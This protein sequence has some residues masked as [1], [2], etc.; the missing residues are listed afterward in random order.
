MYSKLVK[1]SADE[2]RWFC[3]EPSNSTCNMSNHPNCCN[4][5]HQIIEKVKRIVKEVYIPEVF[6]EFKNIFVQT[7]LTTVG[8]PVLSQH[9]IDWLM[10]TS[11]IY[12]IDNIAY[13]G[14]FDLLYEEVG[15]FDT[16]FA[17]NEITRFLLQDY[18]TF[19]KIE[20]TTTDKIIYTFA[21]LRE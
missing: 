8:L 17:A 11:T 5:D 21:H 18:L 4:R 13:D 16:R 6:P 3:V 12:M 7:G 2:I 19:S 20:G 10:Y 9:F 14:K 15:R 1:I